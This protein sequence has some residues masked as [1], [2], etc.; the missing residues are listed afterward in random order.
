MRI[1]RD[2]S[3]GQVPTTTQLALRDATSRQ[4]AAINRLYQPRGRQG[5]I[6]NADDFLFSDGVDEQLLTRRGE[7]QN[8][9]F[10][11]IVVAVDAS[12]T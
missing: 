3:L 1:Y 12:R 7:P 4:V 5:L 11:H 6:A 10:G 2:G 8:G 9:Y